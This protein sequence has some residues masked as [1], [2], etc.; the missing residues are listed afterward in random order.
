[1]DGKSGEYF[2]SAALDARLKS[3]SGYE[4]IGVAFGQMG[5]NQAVDV[6]DSFL[7]NPQ[8]EFR[9]PINRLS[10]EHSHKHQLHF[11]DR[12]HARTPSL[13][14]TICDGVAIP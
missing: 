13:P 14:L 12:R 9:D 8:N 3:R 1:M 5:C 6:L 7:P 10:L 4:Q 11:L 2:V